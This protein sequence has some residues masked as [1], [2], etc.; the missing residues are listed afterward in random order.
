MGSRDNPSV[1]QVAGI[2][3]TGH[4]IQLFAEFILTGF[5]CEIML[6]DVGFSTVPSCSYSRSFRSWSSFH[7]EGR[8]GQAVMVTVVLTEAVEALAYPVFT[9]L[10]PLF[11]LRQN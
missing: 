8:G 10:M 7:R 5:A 3:S 6:Y 4:N 11:Y 1:S 9:P 2:T